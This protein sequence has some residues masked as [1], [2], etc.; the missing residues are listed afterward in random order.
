MKDKLAFCEIALLLKT[1]EILASTISW[2]N[3]VTKDEVF[4][5]KYNEHSASKD[6]QNIKALSVTFS[7]KPHTH[8]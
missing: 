2:M 7:Q 6:E 4:F 3:M 1:R 5:L 8:T